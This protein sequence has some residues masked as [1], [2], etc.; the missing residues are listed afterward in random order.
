MKQ[1]KPLLLIAVAAVVV[2]G[3]CARQPEPIP[4]PIYAEPTFDKLGNPS[5]RPI[6]TPI[7]GA[8]TVDLPICPRIGGDVSPVVAIDTGTDNDGSD[9]GGVVDDGSPVG[10]DVVDYGDV[11]PDDQGGNQNRNQN[12]N[13]NRNNEQN[14][15]QTGS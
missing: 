9:V 1:M 14:R 4:G 5:C 3:G 12:N 8:Y 10:D 11:T 2:L 15:N 13:N 6:N 7:G